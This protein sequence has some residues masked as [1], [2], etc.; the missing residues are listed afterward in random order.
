MFLELDMMAYESSTILKFILK[1]GIF[2]CLSVIFYVYYFSEVVEKYAEGY[3]NLAISKKMLTGGVKLPFMTLCMSPQAKKY[4]LN[5]YNMSILAL[6]EPTIN[7]KETLT[8]L[9][10]MQKDLFMEST[11]Q[12]NKDFHLNITHITYSDEGETLHKTQLNCNDNL[13]QV[14]F[15]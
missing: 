3:T 6:D 7:E 11:F 5:K 2:F 10:M 4:V 9:N 15:E 13:I 14:G 8:N 1:L 12:L